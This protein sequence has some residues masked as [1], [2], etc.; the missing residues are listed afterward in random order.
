MQ[1]TPV[2]SVGIASISLRGFGPNRSLVLVNGKRPTPINALMVTDINGI[3]SALIQRVETITGG[4][5]ATY[6]AD[7][8]SGVT[9]FILKDNFEGFEIDTQFGQTQDGTGDESR[10]SLVLGAN[11]ADGRGNVTLGAERYNRDAV[12]NIENDFFQDY[13]KNP[14]SCGT[15]G[16]QGVNGYACNQNCPPNTTIDGL[17][18]KR[19]AGTNVFT[20]LAVNA[21][22]RTYN[23][24]ADSTVFVAG[25]A[26][27]LSRYKGPVN[28]G[29]YMT[30][31]ALDG[32]RPPGDIEIDSLK[33]YNQTSFV[34][35]PQER[36]SF[37]TSGNFDVSE[38]VEVF[39]RATFAESK[40]KTVLFGTSAV[41]GW[42]AMV[43]YNPTTDSP[44]DPTLDYKNRDIAAAVS[45]NPAAY[46]NPNFIGTGK[47]GARCCVQPIPE[48]PPSSTTVAASSS[49]VR[50]LK[51]PW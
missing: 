28:D 23:F 2:N 26:G 45:A 44:V 30:Q 41:G 22:N 43:P 3:P 12:L 50:S 9:N 16:L 48:F 49:K 33:W 35:A 6:G 34:S 17:F 27:G 31:R 11:L 21:N 24:N 14:Y 25:S 10:I 29:E 42:E 18:S 39:A 20:P 8:V 1:I 4:A 32:S 40:T 5:S 15:F 37:F 7:A 13:M 46:P 36:Y 38:E 19:P 51:P 47:P